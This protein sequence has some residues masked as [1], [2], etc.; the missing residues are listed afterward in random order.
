MFRVQDFPINAFLESMAA[1]YRRQGKRVRFEPFSY[2]ADYVPLL[3][4]STQNQVNATAADAPFICFYQM[5]HCVINVAR[6]L[7]PFPDVLIQ[8]RHDAT[9]RDMQDRPG[10]LLNIFGR[11]QRPFALIR[12]FIIDPKSSWTTTVSNLEAA[13]DFELRL[14]YWGVKAYLT[15]LQ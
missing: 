3:A 4:A 13:T 11:A 6:T 2:N 9:G 1:D 8:I 15:P 12:P 5:Q 7:V 10:H 14:T